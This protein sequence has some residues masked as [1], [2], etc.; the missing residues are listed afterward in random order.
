MAT[1]VK[2]H[3]RTRNGKTVKVRSYTRNNYLGLPKPMRIKRARAT[4]RK[5]KRRPGAALLDFLERWI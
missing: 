3:V 5:V 2:G 1:S 4:W